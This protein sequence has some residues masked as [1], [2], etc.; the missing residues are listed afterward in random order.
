MRCFGTAFGR[1]IFTPNLY[2]LFESF[3]SKETMSFSLF[4]LLP[5]IATEARS[6]FE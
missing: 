1:D 3:C 5:V 2:T 6:T 4:F